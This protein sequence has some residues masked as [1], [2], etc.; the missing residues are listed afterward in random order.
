[1]SVDLLGMWAL[2]SKMY[3]G[4]TYG[5]FHDVTQLRYATYAREHTIEYNYG[6]CSG[7]YLTQLTALLKL[8][9]TAK[10]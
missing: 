4:R 6:F 1:M 9:C 8:H 5:C 10:T 3:I 2:K 7:Q